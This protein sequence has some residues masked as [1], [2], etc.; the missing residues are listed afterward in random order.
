MSNCLSN[1]L[2]PWLMDHTSD[3]AAMA[4]ARTETLTNIQG[5][6]LEIGFG[7]GHSLKHY[8]KET[9]KL[10]AIDCNARMLAKASKRIVASSIEVNALIADASNIPFANDSFDCVVSHMTLCS[11]KDIKATLLEISRVLKPKGCFIFLEHG[12]STNSKT[13]F[14]QN[15]WNPVQKFISDGCNCNREID[16]LIKEAG[17]EIHEL[18]Y[19][20]M[21]DAPKVLDF[22]YQG[23]ATINP[24]NH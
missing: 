2:M 24:L 5:E 6:I 20:H 3:S 21:G 1:T 10:V 8:P 14:W 18:K 4:T 17:Y 7:C 16:T 11:V 9:K 19:Y 13:R 15:C 12:A 23:S 22:M